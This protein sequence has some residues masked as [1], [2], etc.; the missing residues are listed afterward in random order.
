VVANAKS[1]AFD[2]DHVGMRSRLAESF[3]RGVLGR[4]P[5]LAGDFRGWKFDDDDATLRPIPFQ[6]FHLA[7]TNDETAAVLFDRGEDGFAVVLVTDGVVN[8]DADEDVGGHFGQLLG[9]MMGF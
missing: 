6:D 4:V 8:F 5:P 9:R 7:A 3:G 1:D 2:E